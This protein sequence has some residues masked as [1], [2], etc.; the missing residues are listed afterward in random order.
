VRRQAI[1]WGCSWQE[2]LR[3]RNAFPDLKWR[4]LP[5]PEDSVPLEVRV[6]GLWFGGAE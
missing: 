2:P 4:G 1:H 5:G 3:M 6:V